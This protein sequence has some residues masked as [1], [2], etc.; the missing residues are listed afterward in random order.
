MHNFLKMILDK[1]LIS[2]HFVFQISG[3]IILGVSI[4]LKV[5]RNGNVIMDEEVPFD[6]LIA[7]GVI[8]MV[9]GFLGCCGAIKENRCMLILFFI[10]LLL[11]FILLLIAGILG[12]VGE[13]KV[14]ED[15]RL[16][17]LLPLEDE[18][19]VVKVQWGK[20]VFDTLLILYVCPLTKKGSVYNFNGR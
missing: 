17:E 2:S 14:L 9:L 6:L 5:S 13:K 4:Y 20:K 8:I 15:G 19:Y 1:A 12:A 10:G 3:Y 18:N 16:G 11:I 7:A